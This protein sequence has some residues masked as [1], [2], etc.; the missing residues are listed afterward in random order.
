MRQQR[1]HAGPLAWCLILAGTCLL[2]FL[3]Q[4]QFQFLC[5]FQFQ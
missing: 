1:Y 5:Q 2:L 3:F 4:V